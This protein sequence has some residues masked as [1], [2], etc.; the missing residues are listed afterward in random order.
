MSF[1][2][3]KHDFISLYCG[4]CGFSRRVRVSCGDRTCPV[5]SEARFSALLEGY[6]SFLRS[7]KDLRFIT[8]TLKDCPLSIEKIK[9]LRSCFVKLCRMKYYRKALVGG[10][11]GIEAR[12]RAGRN[13][14]IHIHILAEGFYI[15]QKR[16]SKDWLS[17]TGNSLIVD[18]RKFNSGVAGLK[19]ITKY[20]TKPPSVGRSKNLY[21][22]VVRHSRLIH[23]FGTWYRVKSQKIPFPCPLCGCENWITHLFLDRNQIGPFFSFRRR[24][25]P[26]GVRDFSPAKP[27]GLSVSFPEKRYPEEKT[28]K[29]F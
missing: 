5:C 4:D 29:L 18:I 6:H 21:N 15:P 27:A 19:Y 10:L 9:F 26:A 12:K 1:K 22:S 8:L 28:T 11:Y 23:T 24:G 14:Y 20:M 7:K 13:W 16:L 17:L 3:K 25:R 2:E